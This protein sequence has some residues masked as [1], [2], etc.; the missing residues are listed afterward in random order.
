VTIGC[1][2]RQRLALLVDITGTKM[3]GEA[4][5]KTKKHGSDYRNLVSVEQHAIAVDH[6]SLGRGRAS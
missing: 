6:V 2:P 1:S 5:W 3:L 4:E